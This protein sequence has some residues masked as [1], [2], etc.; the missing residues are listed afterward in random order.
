VAT[1]VCLLSGGETTVTIKGKGKG[2][3]STE[4]AWAMNLA[5]TD[6]ILLLSAGTDGTDDP[7]DAAGAF[8]DST[9]ISRASALGRSAEAHLAD[10]D[11]NKFFPC[12]GISAGHG[13]HPHQCDGHADPAGFRIN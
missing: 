12:T 8:A 10:N 7:T 3:R 2:G 11:S 9:T 1:P 13:S 4:L 5:G 6:G